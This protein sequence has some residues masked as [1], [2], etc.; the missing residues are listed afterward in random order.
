MRWVGTVSSLLGPARCPHRTHH[1][2]ADPTGHAVRHSCA[3]TP[4]YRGIAHIPCP[5]TIRRYD[6]GSAKWGRLMLSVPSRSARVRATR[7]TRWWPWV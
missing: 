1:Q 3:D 4:A 7:R 6:S 2:L 5:V